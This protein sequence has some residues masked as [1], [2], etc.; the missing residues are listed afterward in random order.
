MYNLGKSGAKVE[1]AQ[2]LFSTL[3]EKYGRTGKIITIVSI[4]ENNSKAEISPTNYVSTPEEYEIE[5]SDFLNSLKEKSQVV[6]A[7][8]SGYVD[9]S[10]TNPIHNPFNGSKSYFTNE[11][12]KLFEQKFKSL[13]DSKHIQFVDIGL[14]EER[15]KAE[16]LYEDGL[17]LNQKGHQYIADKVMIV[18]EANFKEL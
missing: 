11:R 6:I 10:K 16:Y 18:L 4:G 2:K 1:F 9:E 7:V 14:S 5:I 17:H 13:C 3:I 12:K 15:W 8:G